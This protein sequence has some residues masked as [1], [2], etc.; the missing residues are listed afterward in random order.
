MTTSK[1]L[2]GYTKWVTIG[3]SIVV[4]FASYVWKT[5][6]ICS[7]LDAN[8]AADKEMHTTL[9]QTAKE[10]REA[11]LRMQIDLDYIKKGIDDIRQDKQ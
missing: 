4:I 9:A 7:T 1:G 8:I 10:N 11:I 6:A 5:S 2:N 3:I